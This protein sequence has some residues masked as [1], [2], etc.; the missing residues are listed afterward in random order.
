MNTNINF[1]KSALMAVT[2]F[3][4]S[5]C[6]IE[7]FAQTMVAPYNNDNFWY[8]AT[9]TNAIQGINSAMVAYGPVTSPSV[10][11]TSVYYDASGSSTIYINDLSTG[12]ST[13]IA[14]TAMASVPDVIFGNLNVLESGIPNT[15]NFCV[16]IGFVNT[17]GYV[18]VDIDTFSDDGTTMTTPSIAYTLTTTLYS[19]Q[20]VHLDVL[21]IGI[22]TG[23]GY[24]I[25]DAFVVTWDDIAMGHQY[26]YASYGNK[27]ATL[28]L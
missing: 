5:A 10:I 3:F 24:P 7:L 22:E 6:H 18:E 19:P 2:L 16:A 23:R 25:L 27:N 28:P 20:T 13:S 8:T 15:N 9:N 11:A 21:P 1:K 26:V 17:S 14:T 4:C 12:L